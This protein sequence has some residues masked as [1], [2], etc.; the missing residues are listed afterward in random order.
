MTAFL[1]KLVSYIHIS[2]AFNR[3]SATC[4]SRDRRKI[5]AAV[6]IRKYTGPRF[7]VSRTSR[8]F[9]IS[10]EKK[11]ASIKMGKELIRVKPCRAYN[12]FKHSTVIPK[13]I[14]IA[15]LRLCVFVALFDLKKNIL[16]FFSQ[17]LPVCILLVV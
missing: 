16:S 12:F 8:E 4:Q 2:R 3:S 6:S 7:I 1:L 14:A 9:P 13:S 10:L 17:G 15:P 5:L 11:L